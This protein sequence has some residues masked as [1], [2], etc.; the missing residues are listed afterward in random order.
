VGEIDV[1]FTADQQEVF[2]GGIRRFYE[3]VIVIFG[4]SLFEEFRE[5]LVA[6]AAERMTRSEIIFP[7]LFA[8]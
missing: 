8:I 6:V 4:D 5:N 1:R 7:E 2:F 3:V